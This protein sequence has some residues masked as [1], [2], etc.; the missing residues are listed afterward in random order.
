MPLFEFIQPIETWKDLEA[1]EPETWQILMQ[2]PNADGWPSSQTH[3]PIISE[4]AYLECTNEEFVEIF[5]TNNLKKKLNEI[6]PFLDPPQAE[7][8]YCVS[9]N[10]NRCV[11]LF[12]E[13]LPYQNGWL[14]ARA[15][16]VN[17]IS[18]SGWSTPI[19]VSEPSFALTLTVVI[20]GITI[21]G[22]MKNK[23]TPRS[24]KEQGVFRGQ[25]DHR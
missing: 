10:L 23:K 7:I 15:C 25:K 19:V 1:R 9:T 11:E 8:D 22:K 5:C 21:F 17:L 2:E 16:D 3:V 12:T 24:K 4:S 13:N 18:C 20:L 6:D 14:R